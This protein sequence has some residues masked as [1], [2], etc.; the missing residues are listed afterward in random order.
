[1]RTQHRRWNKSSYTQIICMFIIFWILQK[2]KCNNTTIANTS[3][4][5]TPT[6]LISTTQLTST[7]QT[8]EMSTTMFTSS[9]GNVNTSTG[10]TASSVKGTDVTSTISAIST[11]TS[12]TNV[13]VITT[14]PNGDTN[15]STQHVTDSTVTLKTISLSTNTTTMVNANENVTT[16]LPTCSSPNSTN[17]TIS[18][19]PETLL[20]AAQ[21]DNITITHNLTITSC[22]KTAWLRHFNIS[23]HGKYTHPNIR[24][25]KYYNHSLKILHSRILCE[26]H[27]NYLKHH[28]DLCFTCD[29]N[30]SLSLYGLNFTHSGKYS[31]RC[32][33]TGHPSEQNQNFN[34][35][36]HPRNNTN[37]TH[38]DPWVC[39]EPK[40]EWDTSPH[41]PTNYEDNTATSS[42]DHLYRYN[43]HSNTSHGRRTTWT[44]ALICVACI[45]L[46]FVRRALNK[47][48]HPLSDDISE[49]E[50]IVRYNPEHE[51]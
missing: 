4:S 13:T 28:Y 32:Y 15:S 49:S 1:M 35:Q 20:E 39:E 33:K 23:T 38:V 9:N 31:F 45:L 41:K 40:H 14:S 2:S 27:T 51:D 34:L 37:G 36:I 47:K 43:N 8:T 16:P 25:G 42:I 50:F 7:L 11:Q 3:T 6:S 24:N 21:G 19:E 22:Y 12:T 10:F 46:F 18:K 29:R 17:N 44:L 5:I 26:W 48:Y 30:L